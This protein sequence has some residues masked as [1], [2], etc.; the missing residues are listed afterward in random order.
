MLGREGGGLRETC[1]GRFWLQNQ[2]VS[3]SVFSQQVKKNCVSYAN[4]L[5]RG[6]GGGMNL[7]GQ[8]FLI[9][10]TG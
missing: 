9:S 10:S 7:F 4:T 5:E 8:L 2:F 3:L 6:G 1:M